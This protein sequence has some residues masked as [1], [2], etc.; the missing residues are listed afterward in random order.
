VVQVIDETTNEIVYTLRINGNS[1]R[2]KV[3]ETTHLYTLKI[4]TSTNKNSKL[5]TI[6]NLKSSFKNSILN[7]NFSK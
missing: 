6:R 1:F 3:F 2:P 4:G 5:K 7:V